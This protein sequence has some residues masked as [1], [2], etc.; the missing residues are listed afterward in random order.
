MK[1]LRNAY[2]QSLPLAKEALEASLRTLNSSPDESSASLKRIAHQLRGSGAS[3]GFPAI[4]ESAAIL[5]DAGPDG[6]AGAAASLLETISQSAA[7]EA[8]DHVNILIVE[9]D[10]LIADVLVQLVGSPE[11]EI[12]V[13]STAKE[14]LERLEV[15]P[16]DLIILDLVLPDSD[17]RNLLMQLRRRPDT[18]STPIVMISARELAPLRS[19]CLLLGA[20]DFIEKPFDYEEVQQVIISV[21]SRRALMSTSTLDPLT[22]LPSERELRS[23]FER[24]EA[25]TRRNRQ[26]L[27]IIL[28]D[29]DHF[30]ERN[31]TLGHSRGDEILKETGKFLRE[32]FRTSDIVGRWEGDT[33]LIILPDTDLQS[34][35]KLLRDAQPL[36]SDR[37]PAEANLLP[38]SFSAGIVMATEGSGLDELVGAADQCLFRAKAG[39]R[40]RISYG[41]DDGVTAKPRILLA[42]DDKMIAQ[43]VQHRLGKEG[44]EVIWE[45]N[46]KAALKRAKEEEDLSFILLDV[47]M[48]MMDGY[49]VLRQ[50]RD[51]PVYAETP[52]MLLTSL[53]NEQDIIRGFDLGATD[54]MTK[55]FSPREL[56]ARIVHHLKHRV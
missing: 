3:F 45:E 37:F 26:N 1:Q 36:F 50:L 25:L 53:G 47:K 20:N 33:F 8:D 52:I 24:M 35:E 43:L 14:A 29:I 23:V 19:E 34:A 11:R 22:K 27:A 31:D 40:S 17:G 18:E 38:L 54:Y 5:E 7:S 13:A 42:D 9:P 49:Q 15:K 21:L 56:T 28:L 12:T 46:G 4:S 39:G 16:S 10:A 2:R 30:H 41:K 6:I 44:F 32:R 51:M 55:P 48:P